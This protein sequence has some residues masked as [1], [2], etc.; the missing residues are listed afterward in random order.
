M[1]LKDSFKSMLLKTLEEKGIIIHEKNDRIERGKEMG[2]LRISIE[3]CYIKV[4][5]G[6]VNCF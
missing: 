4:N 6:L 2:I 3:R 5:H 1:A